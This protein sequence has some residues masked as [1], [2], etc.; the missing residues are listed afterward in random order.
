MKIPA[1]LQFLTRSFESCTT[2]VVITDGQGL[3]V[4]ANRAAEVHTGFSIDEMIG[5]R[6]GDL[7]GG[8]MPKEFY[9][10][11]WE[12]IRTHKECFL[13][14]MQNRRK[15]GEIYWQEV[16]I[17]P[18]LGQDEAPIY[19]IGIEFEMDEQRRR[20]EVL[21][22]C[23][24]EEGCREALRV[25]WPFDWLFDL[26]TLNEDQFKVIEREFSVQGKIDRLT[27]DLLILSNVPFKA[28]E[29]S[30]KFPLMPLL[31]E[32]LEEIR[33]EF[34]DRTYFI[35]SES[36]PVTVNQNRTLLKMALQR[37]IRNAA[38]YSKPTIG[39]V[40]LLLI[41]TGNQCTVK[42]DDNGVGVSAHDQPQIFRKFYR[43]LKAR[44]MNP[45]GL[46]LGL[47]IAKQI[48]DVMRWNVD[49]ISYPGTGTS[50]RL[51]L[52]VDADTGV[53]R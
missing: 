30:E 45:L 35:R 27:E 28:L 10:E 23:K 44:T 1:K 7:W 8:Q 43:G 19:Y 34:P 41:R 50:F 18:V 42:V 52:P 47:Y 39:E 13:G 38:Q 4:Y 22:N 3:I 25:L 33:G 21:R 40:V 53:S 31:R 6:P 5:R 2:H 20:E 24:T 15:T 29:D 12:T 36:V 51:Q 14:E 48:A 17:I 46:G 26:T 16:H 9:R 49:F 11:M 37:I 32:V